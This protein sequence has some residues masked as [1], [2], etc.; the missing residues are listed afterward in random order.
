MGRWG[1]ACAFDMTGLLSMGGYALYVWGAYALCAVVLVG[2]LIVSYG[3][4]RARDTQIRRL[5]AIRD[6]DRQRQRVESA[7]TKGNAA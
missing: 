3:R 5:Q 4:L 6:R 7:R 2:L 1:N